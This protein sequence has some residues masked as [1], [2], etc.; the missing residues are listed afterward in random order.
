LQFGR[1]QRSMG[2]VHIRDWP[3]TMNMV[4]LSAPPPH[5]LRVRD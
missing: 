3:P 1:K 4:V 5:L 2:C